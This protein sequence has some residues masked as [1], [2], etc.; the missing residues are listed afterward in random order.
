MGEYGE[1][2]AERATGRIT[3]RTGPLAYSVS[4]IF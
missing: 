4:I 1:A 3:C 2:A